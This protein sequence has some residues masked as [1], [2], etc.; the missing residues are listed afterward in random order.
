MYEILQKRCK[1]LKT[2]AISLSR[3]LGIN[4]NS[5]CSKLFE[6]YEKALILYD[7]ENS[8]LAIQPVNG[9]HP[10][11]YKITKSKWESRINTKVWQRAGIKAGKYPAVWNDQENKL[12]VDLSQPI[13][14]R[15]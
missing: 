7:K 1:R 3:N 2:P 10:E 4:L 6:P 15:E 13:E 12:E 14:L 11:S 9:D 5:A 8:K